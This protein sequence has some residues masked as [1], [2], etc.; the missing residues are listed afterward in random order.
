MNMALIVALVALLAWV[1]LAWFV[2]VGAPA[3]HLLL[4]LAATLFVYGWAK[5]DAKG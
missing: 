1:V 5:A 4:A 3:V 2:L